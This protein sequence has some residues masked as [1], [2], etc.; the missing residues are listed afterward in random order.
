VGQ[1]MENPFQNLTLE[2]VEV[3]AT[4]TPGSRL[5]EIEK[6]RALRNTVRPGGTVPVELKI[7]PWRGEPR[8]IKVDVNVPEDWPEGKYAVV[9]CGADE[10][11][12]QEMREAPIRFAPDDIDSLLRYLGREERRDRLFIRLSEPGQGLAIGRDELPNLPET[13]RAV[14]AGSARRKVT[15]V[16]GSLVTTQPTAYLLR[17]GRRI[18]ITVDRQAPEP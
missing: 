8:W 11:L 15:G 18:E 12:R 14:L 13:M 3:E 10:A 1:V 17:G 5:A 4:I 6:S 2:A 7:R 9:L 16:T